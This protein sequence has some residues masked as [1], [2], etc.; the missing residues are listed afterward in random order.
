V[1][2]D[3]GEE[4][5]DRRPSW[6]QAWRTE[7]EQGEVG[8]GEVE[9]PMG[10]LDPLPQQLRGLLRTGRTGLERWLG[11]E[12]FPPLPNPLNPTASP[13]PTFPVFHQWPAD[14][15]RPTLPAL[16]PPGSS[17][18]GRLLAG[19]GGP[20]TEFYQLELGPTE[21]LILSPPPFSTPPRMVLHHPPGGLWVGVHPEG[22]RRRLV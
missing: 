16:P 2:V 6:V 19:G 3:S 5:R 4:G 7:A 17:G 22:Q 15:P 18:G 12:L 1:W 14:H 11:G 9:D 21:W 20:G 13:Y 8:W 10:W